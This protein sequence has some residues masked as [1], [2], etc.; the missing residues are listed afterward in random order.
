MRNGTISL[1]SNEAKQHLR[2]LTL[3]DFSSRLCVKRR[4]NL[5]LMRVVY[6]H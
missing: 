3:G 4:S 1:E 2:V 6:T 5:G